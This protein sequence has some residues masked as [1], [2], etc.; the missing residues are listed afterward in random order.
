MIIMTI[1]KN[2]NIFKIHNKLI[3]F[4]IICYKKIENKF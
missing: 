3:H 1:I 4:N 2:Y